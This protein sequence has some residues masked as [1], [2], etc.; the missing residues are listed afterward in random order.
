M[1]FI[2]F[3]GFLQFT[4]LYGFLLIFPGFSVATGF[5]GLSRVLP[6][7]SGFVRFF[8]VLPW[9]RVCPGFSGFVGIWQ[10][11]LRFLQICPGF[12]L[13]FRVFLGF[14]GTVETRWPHWRALYRREGHIGGGAPYNRK[15]HIRGPWP[16]VDQKLYHNLNQNQT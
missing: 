9:T 16:D 6:G 4:G 11:L 14:R 1:F 8:R 2:G 7:L 3:N 13:F 15:A 12:P 5:S 10:N